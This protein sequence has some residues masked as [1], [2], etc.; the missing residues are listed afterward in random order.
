MEA[1]ETSMAR[2]TIQRKTL[3]VPEAA[4]V[5][6]IGERSAYVAAQNG[7]IPSLKI[8]NRRVIPIDALNDY[9]AGRWSPAPAAIALATK[10][11]VR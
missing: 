5:L 8:G 11:G 4:A 1:S 2:S 7:E 9:I 3:T 10:G 6:G